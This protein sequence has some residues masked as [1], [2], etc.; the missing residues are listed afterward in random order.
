MTQDWNS[1]LAGQGLAADGS[2]F[3]ALADELAAARDGDGR[4]TRWWTSA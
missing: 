3:G 4:G 2:S 1:L